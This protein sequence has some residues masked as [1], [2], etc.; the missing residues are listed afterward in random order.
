MPTPGRPRSE[1]ARLAVLGATRDLV[2]AKGYESVTL[3]EIAGAAAVGRQTIYRWWRTKEALV[4]EAVLEQALPLNPVVVTPSGDLRHDL[5]VWVEDSVSRIADSDTA[6]LYRALLAA[7]AV[8][9]VAAARMT[10]AFADPLRAAV[11]AAFESTGRGRH[12]D[13]AADM[14]IGVMTNAIVSRDP[15]ARDRFGL[16]VDVIVSGTDDRDLNVSAPPP[17]DPR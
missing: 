10:A 7:S 11:T 9:D 17:V 14:L 16:V 2:L 3:V 15:G 5:Q 6:A 1:R 12:A 13:V 8:D 4:A